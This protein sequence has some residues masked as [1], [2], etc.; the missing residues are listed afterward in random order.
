MDFS[1]IASLF[2]LV[3]FLALLCIFHVLQNFRTAQAAIAWIVGLISF[4]YITVLLYFFF[5]R[6][7]FEGYV[8]ARRIGDK[9]LSHI[10]DTLATHAEQCI[11]SPPLQ[12]REHEVITQ[13]TT[14]PF[15]LHNHAQLLIDGL[16]TYTSMFS[17][18]RQ[19]KEYIL[20]EFY[21]VR[22]D[23][24]G[25]KLSN[26]LLEKLSEGVRVYFLYDDVGS[27]NLSSPFIEK[28]N[29]AGAHIRSFNTVSKRRKRFQINFRNHRKILIIDGHTGFLGGLN[30][31]DEYLGLN[32]KLSPWRDTHLKLIGPSV[33]ALQVTFI[34]DWYWSADTVPQLNWI[35][36]IAPD[37]HEQPPATTTTVTRSIDGS[38]IEPPL[39]E[40]SA[41]LI[42]PT[43]A[44]D[45][46]DTCELFFL[47][48]INH[49]TER[50]WIAS[51]YFVPD[52]Q[53][54]SALQLAS[55]R[56][57]DVRIMIPDNP[58]HKLVYYAAFSYLEATDLSGVKVYRYKT[59]F[60]HQKVM[61]VDNRY[62]C[63]GTAN[64]DNR[65]MRLNFEVTALICNQQ[66]V[67][68]VELMLKKDFD[69][70][71]Q[72]TA[73]YYRQRPWAFRVMC[74]GARLL[75]PLL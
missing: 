14:M 13:L 29:S 42:I 27:A 1:V 40:S 35:P 56:G 15:T 70:C 71:Q 39:P 46:F 25:N 30:I 74:R 72:V 65:S 67:R 36:T 43:S 50:L 12:S 45:E 3:Y 58:D 61:L 6:N 57:V 59:G 73:Q 75:A 26:L 55:L 38:E 62:A 10:A 4:P 49:A 7:R 23:G 21:I 63:V 68:D 53:I 17:A 60:M 47:N 20:I 31:G 37:H 54:I 52:I 66:V 28:L 2:S 16:Q 48:C 18:I 22:D 33:L 64:I 5:G 8:A 9:E 44:A 11:C 69:H 41:V 24:I 34:E 19:A 51:P 32:P